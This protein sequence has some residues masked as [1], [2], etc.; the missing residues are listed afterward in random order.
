MIRRIGALAWLPIAFLDL[1]IRRQQRRKQNGGGNAGI[2]AG[3]GC[4][5]ARG[6]GNLAGAFVGA[7]WY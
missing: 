5:A 1:I 3:V 4:H 7:H 6:H 2:H